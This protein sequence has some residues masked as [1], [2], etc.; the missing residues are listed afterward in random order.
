LYNGDRHRALHGAMGNDIKV[1]YGV[2]ATLELAKDVLVVAVL[3]L[4]TRR[5]RG[6]AVTLGVA[7]ICAATFSWLATHAH[8]H[9]GMTPSASNG[10]G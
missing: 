7:W 3:A 2:G 6:L 4:W 8:R 5:A 9:D 1:G 10:S